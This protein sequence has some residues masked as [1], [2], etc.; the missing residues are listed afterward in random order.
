VG[1]KI[2]VGCDLISRPISKELIRRNTPE[3][4]KN[5]SKMWEFRSCKFIRKGVQGKKKNTATLNEVVLTFTIPEPQLTCRLHG[6]TTISLLPYMDVTVF[7]RV[8]KT[9]RGK[10]FHL[11]LSLFMYIRIHVIAMTLTDKIKDNH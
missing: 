7:S 3:G 6:R 9:V 11:S 5:A 10:K 8:A 4:S 1:T 2:W